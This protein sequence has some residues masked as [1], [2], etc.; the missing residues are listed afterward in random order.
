MSL[1]EHI[2][3]LLQGPARR[4]GEAEEHMQERGEVERPEDE[5]S[6]VG[7]GG[8][9]G[10][11]AERERHVEG[12]VRGGGDGDGFRTD[13]HGEDFG[14][15]GP[16]DGTDG[17]CESVSGDYTYDKHHGHEG[18]KKMRTYEHTARYEQTM[19]PFVTLPLSAGILQT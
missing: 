2:L 18:E 10:G 19:T 13:A 1:R 17:N 15:V 8:E 6:F 7:N 11:H 16:G 4:L 12:P 5:V 9:T 3:D 14:G